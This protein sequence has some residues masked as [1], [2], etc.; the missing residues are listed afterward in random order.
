MQFVNPSHDQVIETIGKEN[1]K[2]N[3][4]QVDELIDL[5]DKEE[6]L[7][8]EDKILP[9][10]R[11]ISKSNRTNPILSGSKADLSVCFGSGGFA[12]RARLQ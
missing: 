11:Q 2:L 12:N 6:E 4:K 9:N 10:V 7:E 8:A 3:A 5:L 1:V